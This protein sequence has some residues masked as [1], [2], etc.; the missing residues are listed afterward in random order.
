MTRMGWKALGVAFRYLFAVLIATLASALVFSVAFYAGAFAH[1]LW[2]GSEPPLLYGL[3]LFAAVV[4]ILALPLV[5]LSALLVLI[6]KLWPGL[7]GRPVSLA[8]GGAIA[9]AAY[10]YFWDEKLNQY[11]GAGALLLA[12]V[13]G[14]EVFSRLTKSPRPS[15]PACA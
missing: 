1:A 2:S 8:T 6:L 3:I 10:L 13:V 14:A 15:T 12:V 11:A 4:A 9:A 7:A 5:A